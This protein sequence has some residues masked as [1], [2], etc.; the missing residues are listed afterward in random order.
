MELKPSICLSAFGDYSSP[1]L[2]FFILHSAFFVRM[3]RPIHHFLSI[4]SLFAINAGQNMLN[5]TM[6]GT[7]NDES[8]TR[9][10]RSTMY[11][12]MKMLTM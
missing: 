3:H 4:F 5:K 2:L 11:V 12:V 10:N 7:S 8:N 1:C 6:N 9:I